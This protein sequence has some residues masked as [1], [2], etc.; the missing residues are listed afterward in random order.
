MNETTS[1]A[2]RARFHDSAVSRVTR[3]YA[4]TLP[5]IFAETLQNA[6]RAGATRVR[7]SLA[8]PEDRPIVTVADDGA[9]I[10]RPGVLL[11]F[12]ENGWDNELVR[13]EDAAGMGMLS[14]A[15]RGCTVASRPRSPN[16]ESTTGWRVQTLAR[17][18]PRR[19]R[20]GGVDGRRRALPARHGGRVRSDG[21]RER[22]GH[23]S[24]APERRPA[25]PAARPLR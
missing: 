21:D 23:P 18:L 9:G 14:L 22:R 1:R 12:G 4:A 17:A 11:S 10:A 5:D 24:G 15:R 16:D 19:G 25:L 13:R 3:M 20:G 7:V 2:I 6:R 8:G